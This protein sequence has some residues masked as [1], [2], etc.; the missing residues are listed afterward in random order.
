MYTY[1]IL[2]AQTNQNSEMYTWNE[3]SRFR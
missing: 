2:L 3:V 1:S